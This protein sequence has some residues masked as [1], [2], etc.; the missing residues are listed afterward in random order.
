MALKGP[1]RSLIKAPSSLLLLSL[2]SCVLSMNR[3][4]FIFLHPKFEN[5]WVYHYKVQVLDFS[6][7][8][9]AIPLRL[10]SIVLEQR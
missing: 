3:I 8:E 5:D 10:S 7:D 4:Y 9:L 2:I 1:I 6:L